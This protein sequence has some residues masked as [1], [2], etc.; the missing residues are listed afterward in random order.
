MAEPVDAVF[1][2]GVF[3]YDP[4]QRVL[5]RDNE[6]VPLQPKAIDLLELLLQRRGEAISRDE[7]MKALW[8]DCVVEEI[9]LARNV[10]LLRKAL[11]ENA[12]RY[13]ETIPKRG[14]RFTAGVQPSPAH[15]SRASGLRTILFAASAALIVGVLIYWQFY[16]SSRFFPQDSGAPTI[17]VIP[18]D[19]LTSDTDPA[20]CRALS[21][22]LATEISKLP[23]IRVTSPSTVRRYRRVGIPIAV[24]DRLLG[25][26]AV[27]E[28]TAQRF[29]PM[30][31]IS[32]RLSDAHSGR[33]IWADSYDVAADEPGSGQGKIAQAVAMQVGTRIAQR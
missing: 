33:L 18:F 12:E 30:V 31:R 9:G 32:V 27:I 14:Y 29:G 16:R 3:R 11:G 26:D 24:M 7:L 4:V 22:V 15:P 2:F 8:P 21:D 19:R 28:G 10:S 5:L 23:R 17:A 25:L 1:R 13:I 20:F 6:V